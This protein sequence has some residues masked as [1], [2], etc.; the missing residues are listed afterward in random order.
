MDPDTRLRGESEPTALG[1]GYHAGLELWY[2]S[3]LDGYHPPTIEQMIEVGANTIDKIMGGWPQSAEWDRPAMM[4]A[5]D[6]ML[7]AYFRDACDHNF[8]VF[9]VEYDVESEWFGKYTIAGRLD[10]VLRTNPG[11]F[12][13]V[14]HKSAGKAW[15]PDKHKPRYAMQAP[16]Y[17]YWLKVQLEKQGEV[18]DSIRF[19]YDVMTRAGKFSRKMADPTEDEIQLTLERA[20]QYVSMLD[21]NIEL[22]VS[23]ESFLCSQK[24][25]EYWEI[26]PFGSRMGH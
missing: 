23:T 14:D 12:L 9:G 25:C 13:I 16:W 2:Q 6:T 26:C 10:L 8:E 17:S 21:L 5:L 22:P 19:C 3:R 11:S 7:Y 4:T 15:G 18:V 20:R 1:T 24:Y